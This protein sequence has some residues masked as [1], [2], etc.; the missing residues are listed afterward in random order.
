MPAPNSVIFHI[1]YSFRG[2]TYEQ[3]H[4]LD[5]FLDAATA[6]CKQNAGSEQLAQGVWLIDL[7]TGLPHLGQMV[8]LAQNEGIPYRTFFLEHEPDWISFGDWS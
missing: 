6:L 7:K 1:R 3:S 2:C 8:V 5:R 4:A